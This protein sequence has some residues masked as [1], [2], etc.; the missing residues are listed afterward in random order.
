MINRF[1][2]DNSGSAHINTLLFVVVT[3]IFFVLFMTYA[4][5][6]VQLK[7]IQQVAEQTLNKSTTLT[8][9][10]IADSVKNGNDYT[11]IINEYRFTDSISYE[12]GL[13]E[14][15]QYLDKNSD[16]LYEI[17]D[18]EFSFVVNERLNTKVLFVVSIPVNFLHIKTY[19][20]VPMTIVSRYKI[21][22]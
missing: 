18:F 16:L 1:K 12:L 2:Q 21:K 13:N 20:N 11:T 8:A 9:I 7:N 15:N 22:V 4:S 19:I 14:N 17:S 3:L 5:C 10:Q 6:L